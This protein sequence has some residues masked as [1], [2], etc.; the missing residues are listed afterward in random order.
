[1]PPNTPT[2]NPRRFRRASIFRSQWSSAFRRQSALSL[3]CRR[4]SSYNTRVS[5]RR[6]YPRLHLVPTRVSR[7]GI[8]SPYTSRPDN[9]GRKLHNWRYRFSGLRTRHCTYFPCT[10]KHRSRNGAPAVHTPVHLAMCRS[11]RMLRAPSQ[12]TFSI[13]GRTYR[14]ICRRRIRTDK[15]VR[16]ATYR[17]RS[18][19]EVCFR[20]IV[21]PR[22]H[23]CP[24]TSHFDMQMDTLRLL[25]TFHSRR[26]SA[27]PCHRNAFHWASIARRFHQDKAAS[28]PHTPDSIATIRLHRIL[29]ARCR[30]IVSMWVRKCPCT[31]HC[32]IRM[33][34]PPCLAKRRCRRMLGPYCRHNART[35]V[36]IARMYH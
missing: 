22:V 21:V 10:Y 32:C 4:S 29:A 30:H 27:R 31:S 14:C 16:L 9:H 28:C 11:Y 7:V 2:L 33:Y 12:N 3:P 13:L 35:P 6:R 17:H 20:C 15:P 25:A 23:K 24:C 1:M 34:R 18:T 36:R 19:F 5:N 26:M 8:R